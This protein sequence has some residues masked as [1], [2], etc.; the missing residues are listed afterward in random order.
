[1]SLYWRFPAK[2]AE[3]VA[4]L[5]KS[6]EAPRLIV[7]LAFDDVQLLDVA[8]PLQAFASANEMVCGTRSAPSH[9]APYHIAVVSHAG[10]PIRSSSGLPL[11]TQPIAK[12]V[13]ARRIDTLI[14]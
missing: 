13:G 9:G 10:G 6:P 7:I 5:R 14:L 12:A 11:L 2:P 8:G 1:M 3:E 4:A